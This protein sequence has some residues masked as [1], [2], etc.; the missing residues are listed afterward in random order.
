M[1]NYTTQY[2]VTF[3]TSYHSYILCKQKQMFFHVEGHQ[4]L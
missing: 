1:N 3:I 4:T 2:Q